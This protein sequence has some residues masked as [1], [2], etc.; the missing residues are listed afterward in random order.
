M[1][2]HRGFVAYNGTGMRNRNWGIEERMMVSK[3]SRI[4]I[5]AIGMLVTLSAAVHAQTATY[6]I[7]FEGTW[8]AAN[9]HPIPGGAHFSPLVG[10]THNSSVELWRNG[11]LATNG[12]ERMAESGS[13]IPLR[14]EILAY[15]AENATPYIGP[16]IDNDGTGSLMIEVDASQSLLTLVTM[17]APSPDWFIGTSGF[18]LRP[19]GEW[20]DGLV[21]D[22]FAYDSGTD[23][24]VGFTSP[25]SD[26]NPQEPISLL[27]SPLGGLPPIGTYTFNLLSVS[28]LTGDFDGDGSLGLTDVDSLVAEIAGDSNVVSFDLTGDGNVDGADLTE[29][30]AIA[31]AENLPSGNSYLVGDANLDGGVD[32]ADFNLWNAS[33]FTADNFWSGGDFNADGVTDVGDFNLWNANR[34]TS[35]ADSASAVPEPATAGMLISCVLM[36][37]GWRRRK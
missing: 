34:F 36:L 19:G 7:L 30:L 5:F 31:G 4:L 2:A 12:I 10:A 21:Y 15:G 29:W 37:W 27:G 23:N 18:D 25:N 14:N 16:G 28:G 1:S 17:I 8:T 11:G 32:V 13:V 35:A 22:L 9:N 20:V 26:T 6:E 33:R 24:G 3:S